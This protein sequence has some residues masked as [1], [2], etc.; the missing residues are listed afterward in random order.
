MGG[1][2]QEFNKDGDACKLILCDCN[3]T[4]LGARSGEALNKQLLDFLVKAKEH[5]FRVVI[6]SNDSDGNQDTLRLLFKRHLKDPEFF[7]PIQDKS[8]YTGAKALMVFDDDHTSHAADAAFR[9]DPKDDKTIT[10]L[11]QNLFSVLD[12]AAVPAA[13]HNRPSGSGQ[14]GFSANP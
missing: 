12:Y 9:L 6:F 7:G 4:L 10:R 13:Q 11:S 2:A 8:D 1:F 3:N 14:S 5:G